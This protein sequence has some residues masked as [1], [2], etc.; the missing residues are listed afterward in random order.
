[1]GQIRLENNP[2]VDILLRRSRRAKRLS[3][4]VSAL[5]G[6]VTLTVPPGASA[7]QAQQFADEHSD[8]IGKVLMKQ[9]EPVPVRAGA[10]IPVGGRT[11]TVATA[12]GRSARIEGAYLLAPH[13]R[14][15]PAIAALLKHM[16]RTRLS[17]ASARYADLIGHEFKRISLRDTRSR[18]G[19]CSS[20]GSLMYSWRLILAPPEILDYVAAHEVAHLA[21]MNHSAAFWNIVTRICPDY[22]RH[23]KWLRREGNDLHR[24]RF[25]SAGND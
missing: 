19:S 2:A 10:A 7:R 13:G 14:E 20:D 4:R 21:E 8:W 24:F 18:W 15:G 22:A 16:A 11:F 9:A 3:L 25:D 23:R 17:E 5:D 12:A 6:R 1:M